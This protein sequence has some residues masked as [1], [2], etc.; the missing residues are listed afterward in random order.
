[1][2]A[3]TGDWREIAVQQVALWLEVGLLGDALRQMLTSGGPPTGA[4]TSRSAAR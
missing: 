2:V 1:V 4:L 3:V